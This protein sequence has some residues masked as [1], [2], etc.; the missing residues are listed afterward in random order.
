MSD[1]RKRSDDDLEPDKIGEQL[2]KVHDVPDL[3]TGTILT[4]YLKNEGIQATLAPV[5][6]SMLPGVES[7]SHGYWGQ[8]EV[9][10]RDADRA[11]TL[12]EEYLKA[13]PAGAATAYAPDDG[14]PEDA[15]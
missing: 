11:R 14:D 12:I 2:V 7:T 10:E 4:D 15:A 5:D 13:R 3:V 6:I 1:H 9:L 8:I